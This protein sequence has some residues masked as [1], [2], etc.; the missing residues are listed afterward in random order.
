MKSLVSFFFKIF[1]KLKKLLREPG[2]FYS[3]LQ[4]ILLKQ[5]SNTKP[6]KVTTAK[7]KLKQIFFPK[8]LKKSNILKTKKIYDYRKRKVNSFFYNNFN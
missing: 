7:I 3:S 4:L 1:Q 5:V 8:N 2:K 6:I